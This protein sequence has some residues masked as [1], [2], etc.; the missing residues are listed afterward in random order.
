MTA[1]LVARM[2]VF[3]IEL[4]TTVVVIAATLFWRGCD[5]KLRTFVG[6]LSTP[7]SQPNW[8]ERTF[9]KI[10]SLELLFRNPDL[11]QARVEMSLGLL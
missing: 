11:A 10:D 8:S 1:Y 5:G 4:A 2:I 9:T 6:A 7:C 3:G